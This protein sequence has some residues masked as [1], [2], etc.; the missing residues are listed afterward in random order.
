MSVEESNQEYLAC[1]SSSID[2]AWSLNSEVVR[3]RSC[4]KISKRKH[5][6]RNKSSAWKYFELK[7]NR[8]YC[9]Q[10]GCNNSNSVTIAKTPLI[11]HLKNNHDIELIVGGDEE[12]SEESN[13]VAAR[14]YELGLDELRTK[15]PK[16]SFPKKFPIQT[17]V[18][19]F[20]LHELFIRFILNITNNS[21]IIPNQMI[22]R[23]S[24]LESK[25]ELNSMKQIQNN[26]ESN[27]YE[28]VEDYENTE[29]TNANNNNKENIY[30]D[31]SDYP[32]DED[33]NQ[34]GYNNYYYHKNNESNLSNWDDE[35][36][37]EESQLHFNNPTTSK[38]VNKQNI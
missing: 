15:L 28:M 31:Y 23:P 8:Y 34:N 10:V 25:Q 12:N 20:R 17:H 21:N 24:N 5:A 33:V 7:N 16:F 36:E 1:T 29:F 9:L 6:Y 2:W 3:S 32:E 35:E 26:H 13:T 38:R 22:Q 27:D 19:L 30:D 37:T 11:A 4:P 18:L 14:W